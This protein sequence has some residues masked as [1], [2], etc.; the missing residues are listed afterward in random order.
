MRIHS[1]QLKKSDNCSHF[2][3]IHLSQCPIQNLE[4]Y[5][6]ESPA[7]I[8]YA[9][10]FAAGPYIVVIS[11]VNVENQFFL[12]QN[13]KFDHQYYMEVVNDAE[14]LRTVTDLGLEIGHFLVFRRSGVEHCTDI[15]FDRLK[16]HHF[17]L[18]L[19]SVVETLEDTST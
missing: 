6:H 1:I 13:P 18:E 16:F 8:A 9:C 5:S 15:D 10:T 3:H 12:L 2:C 7:L 14:N 19:F 4:S 11:H 17:F